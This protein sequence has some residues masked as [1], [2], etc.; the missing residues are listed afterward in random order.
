MWIVNLFDRV[1][2]NFYEKIN[3]YVEFDLKMIILKGGEEI[4][5]VFE[6]KKCEVKFKVCF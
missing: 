3:L 4:E 1:C 6:L 5:F 2:K